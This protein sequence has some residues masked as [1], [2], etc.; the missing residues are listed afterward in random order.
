MAE[1][2]TVFSYSTYAVKL[3]YK[4]ISAFFSRQFRQQAPDMAC[5]L[6]WSTLR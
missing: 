5:G 2:G 1:F 3:G 4:P 6:V